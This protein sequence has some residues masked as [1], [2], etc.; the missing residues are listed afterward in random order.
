MP[1]PDAPTLL[2][3]Y[4]TLM[5]GGSN[6]AFLADQHFLAPATT[7]PGHRLFAL[8]GYPGMIADPAST[9]TVPGE[10]WSVTPACLAQLDQLE[11]LAEGLY[12]RSPLLLSPPHAALACQ[13][14]YYL[15]DLTHRPELPHGWP[16]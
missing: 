4:G 14:Y 13:T 11:G 16:A 5:R 10:L 6:H 1:S 12:S 3:V 9:A 2:F 8:D 15:R 7:T